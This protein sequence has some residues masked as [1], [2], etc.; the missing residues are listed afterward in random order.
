MVLA[1]AQRERVILS[2]SEQ[3][4]APGRARYLLVGPAV[5][6]PLGRSRPAGN[7]ESRAGLGSKSGGR[8]V[9][10]SREGP[11]TA[12]RASCKG[13]PRGTVTLQ[14]KEGPGRS[15][16]CSRKG[17]VATSRLRLG[18]DTIQRLFKCYSWGCLHCYIL[19][20]RRFGGAGRTG[21][22][23]GRG[24][25]TSGSGGCSASWPMGVRA[26]PT[27]TSLYGVAFG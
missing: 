14:F 23:R 6:R 27:S 2:L 17:V 12:C 19:V 1:E 25:A 7:L 9:R 15:S 24:D 22:A 16:G 8:L 18:R 20:L 11:A 5:G 26:L 10:V 21:P 4:S 3:V 13:V